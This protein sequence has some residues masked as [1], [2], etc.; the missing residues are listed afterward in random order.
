MKRYDIGSAT[1]VGGVIVPNVGESKNGEF[2]KFEDVRR[3]L[4][5]FDE[6]MQCLRGMR[7]AMQIAGHPNICNKMDNII[8]RARALQ[9]AVK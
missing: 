2:V 4:D 5:M 6:M 9:E 3:K 7:K 1:C 8:N